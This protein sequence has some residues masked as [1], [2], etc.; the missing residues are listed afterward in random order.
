MV[1][2]WALPADRERTHD[3]EARRVS[4][5]LRLL[6]V[7]DSED[8]A[9]LIVNELRRHYELT[10]E[11]VETRS[12][13]QEALEKDRWD[14]IISEYSMPQFSGLASLALVR[15]KNLDIPFIIVSGTFG[16]ETAVEAMKAGARDYL[17]KGNLARLIP[18]ID[19]ELQE[20]KTRQERRQAQEII[21]FMAYHDPLTALPNRSSLHEQLQL[22]IKLAQREK[23]T[24]A[25]LL[26]DLDHFKEIN[27]T[28]GHAHGDAV[29][30]E[31]GHRL[32]E[33]L[34]KSD[35]VAR[36]GG[37]EFAILLPLTS[38]DHAHIVAQ[39]IRAALEAPFIMENL[40]IMVEASIGIAFHPTH[41]DTVDELIQRAD[42]AMY[43]AKHHRS[44][45]ALYEQ[46]LD[47]HSTRRL[48]LMAELRQAIEQRGLQLY[49]QPKVEFKSGRVIG[50]EG[51]LRWRH[52]EHGF[53]PPDQFIG[54][55]EQTGLIFPLTRFVLEEAIHQCHVWG[56]GKL[57][58]CTS[59]NLSPQNLQD[60]S[61][62]GQVA[63]LMAA[64]GLSPACLE[65]ELTETA[66]MLNPT[67]ALDVLTRFHE[68]GVTLSI[69][70]FGIGYSSLAYLKKLPIDTIKIDKSFV[71]GMMT[72][73][74]DRIIVRSTI[75][76]G[77]NL[78]MKVTA[79]GVENQAIWERLVDYGCD[80]AQGYH[81]SRPMPAADLPLWLKQSSSGSYHA[82]ATR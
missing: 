32:K 80:L 58:V 81:I 54:L 70:D 75:D 11:R 76:L 31:V 48:S 15:E 77:H 5:P 73:E 57:K 79:E 36:L 38:P 40:P 67:R 22:A 27:D 14:L 51:L 37:D 6:L 7:E 65:L 18:A 46:T 10:Y 12:A 49:Y 68:M 30:Q 44:G 23:K 29:L 9:G 60:S 26:L 34:R 69:D 52:A 17:I 64:R 39:K 43:V 50:V 53:I 55:A 33:I 45:I 78:G 8:D 62:P 61:L 2:T 82:A 19:R 59:I 16:E 56:R 25:L 42:I 4:I 1:E 74:N 13:A 35:M 66:I 71:L 3:G 63:E 41:G 21:N 28:L 72:D 24:V 20:A 47:Q